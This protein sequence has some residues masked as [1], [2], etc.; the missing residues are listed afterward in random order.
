MASEASEAT[1]ASGESAGDMATV[2][3]ALVSSARRGDAES[4]RTLCWACNGASS[5]PA[6]LEAELAAR[7]AGHWPLAVELAR[8]RDD[9]EAADA[10][11]AGAG[12]TL[13]LESLIGISALSGQDERDPKLLRHLVGAPSFSSDH[14][15]R[16][17]VRACSMGNYA[18]VLLLIRSGKLPEGSPPVVLEALEKAVIALAC[19]KA[20]SASAPASAS[21]SAA[22]AAS[23]ASSAEEDDGEDGP[24]QA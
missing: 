6:L 14:A 12:S 17:L 10:A 1:E 15:G 13:T 16:A 3:E 18:A 19:Q 5:R 2:G 22:S 7:E 4:A 20:A 23:S 11:G 21:E 9:A 8:F 24:G